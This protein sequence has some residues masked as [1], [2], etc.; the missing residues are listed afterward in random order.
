MRRRLFVL[1]LV[2]AGGAIGGCGFTGNL[3]LDPGFASFGT[4]ATLRETDRDFALSLGPVPLR[5][6]TM[7]SRPVLGADEPWIPEALAA[8][9]AV[10]VYTYEL[11]GETANVERHLEETADALVAAGWRAITA[12]RDDGEHVSALVMQPEPLL[13]RGLVVIARDEDELVL[14]NVIGR[15][16]PDSLNAV[17]EGLELE[18][19]PIELDTSTLEAGREV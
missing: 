14:V 17:L 6:A 11:D 18:L 7:I 1:V 9:R 8:T 12:V 2:A 3:R 19:P 13:I 15:F 4:P 16:R 10:R 5:L